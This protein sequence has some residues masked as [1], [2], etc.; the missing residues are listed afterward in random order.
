MNWAKRGLIFT[1]DRNHDWMVSHAQVP[2]VD[3]VNED[4]LRIYF[5]TRDERNRTVTT[6]IEVE[7]DDPTDCRG[8]IEAR[9]QP[10]SEEAC[11]PGDCDVRH[12]HRLTA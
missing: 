2:L 1:P 10:L 11:D 3:R 9:Q 12:I 4:V 7:A 6:Y 8:G 5:G